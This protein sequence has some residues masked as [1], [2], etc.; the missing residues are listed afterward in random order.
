MTSDWEPRAQ[1]LADQV[2]DPPSRWRAPVAATPR[3]LLV[4][5][6]WQRAAKQWELRDGPADQPGWLD[7]A[8]HDQTLVTRVGSAHADHAQPDDHPT[9]LA[10]SSSTLP[11]LV[12]RML[13]HARVYDGA[14]ILDVGTGTGYAT[15]L[16]AHRLGAG[17]V[18]SIDVDSYLTKAAAERLDAI[19][20]HPQIITC[21]A[22][23]AL[24]GAYNRIV[25]MVSVRPIPPSWLAALRSGG[26][27]VTTITGMTVIITADKRQDGTAVGQ[28]EWDRAGFMATRHGADYPPDLHARFGTVPDQDGE[29]ITKGRYPVV[30]VSEAWELQSVLSVLAPGIEHYYQQDDDG[31]RTAWMVHADGSWARASVIGEQPPIVHQGGPRRLWDILDQ[32]R[33]Y[34]LSHGYFQLYG[35]KALITPDG[36][37]H[38]QRG[39]WQA[40]IT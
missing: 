33:Q 22:T 37:I 21:D 29:Q 39:H 19:G 2:T 10:T 5:R 18:T 35:A 6:W 11:S 38:L 26:R 40:T 17:H 31:R 14:D 25:S 24:P 27:L 8:Y 15:A 28:V 36:S 16:L 23:G 32:T 7:A 20:M 1:R 4:P 13:R 12:V 9:G 34:W 30:N 3:H